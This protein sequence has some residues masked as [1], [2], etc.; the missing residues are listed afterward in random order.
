MNVEIIRLTIN[1]S[2]KSNEYESHINIFY[3]LSLFVNFQIF[4]FFLANSILYL[5]AIPWSWSVFNFWS[6][7]PSNKC[8]SFNSLSRIFFPSSNLI[9]KMNLK[10]VTYLSRYSYLRFSSIIEIYFLNSS[11]CFFTICSFS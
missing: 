7:I 5:S 3:I 4:I 6:L 1:Y 2:N 8:F 10:Y 9:K 11:A